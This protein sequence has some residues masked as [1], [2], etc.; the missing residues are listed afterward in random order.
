MV[1]SLLTLNSPDDSICWVISPLSCLIE[2]IRYYSRYLSDISSWWI[3]YYNS[4]LALLSISSFLNN[5]LYN[6]KPKGRRLLFL[7]NGIS[8]LF[9]EFVD[10]LFLFDLKHIL[11]VYLLL[12]QFLQTALQIK[13]QVFLFDLHFLGQLLLFPLQIYHLSHQFG[14][15]IFLLWLD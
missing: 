4:S 3:L 6:S 12:L 7:C 1:F 15:D 5:R 9:W 2:S 14:S 11:G 13:M 10:D 8:Q